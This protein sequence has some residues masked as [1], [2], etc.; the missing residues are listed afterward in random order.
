ME[1]NVIAQT[2]SAISTWPTEL[3]PSRPLLA[4]IARVFTGEYWTRGQ[5]DGASRCLTTQLTVNWI[6]RPVGDTG[7][8]ERHNGLPG[9]LQGRIRTVSR[10]V[11]A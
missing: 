1:G 5:R 6:A 4:A 10:W 8:S 11:L 7:R 9:E 2:T 3:N